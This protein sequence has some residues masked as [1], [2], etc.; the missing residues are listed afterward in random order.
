MAK[1]HIT[2]TTCDICGRR[3]G[4]DP[5]VAEFLDVRFYEPEKGRIYEE[6]VDDI[7]ANCSESLLD[8]IRG[9]KSTP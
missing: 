1:E 7:C 2:I 4:D 8:F 6:S 3:M 5:K 9:N